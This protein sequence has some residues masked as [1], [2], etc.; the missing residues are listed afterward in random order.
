VK[1]IRQEKLEKIL[2]RLRT[3]RDVQNRDLRTWLG[4]AGFAAFEA[5][6]H[7]QLE[8]R[9]ELEEKPDAV[10]DYE[11]RFRDARLLENRAN[12]HAAR[13]NMQQARKLRAASEVA[14]ER[15]LEFFQE[16]LHADPWLREWFDRF[17]ENDPE[18]APS[19]IAEC[20]PHVVTS[21][22]TNCGRSH[23]RTHSLKTKRDVKIDAVSAALA[24]CEPTQEH[25]GATQDGTGKLRKFL[26]KLERD[27]RS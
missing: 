27:Q 1:N 10:T 24:E 19:L 18:T 8:L 16:Q 22:S 21:R 25:E 26:D 23:H 17:P 12:G 5:A 7:E 14:Y 4:E 11:R 13:G 15:L 9:K 6:W 3:G 20:M 2:Q